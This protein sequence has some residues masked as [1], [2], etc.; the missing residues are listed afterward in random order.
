MRIERSKAVS[1]RI[2]AS[3][4]SG[5]LPA[6][7]RLPTHR[8]LARKHGIALATATKAY[9]EL[10]DAG[11]TVGERGRGTFVRDL[12]G[13]AGPDARRIP[14]TDRVADLSFNQPLAQEQPLALRR[15]LREL[16]SEG[17]L[18]SL[19]RQSPP[20]GH[21]RERAAVA[22]YLLGRGIDVPPA[23]V[24]LTN[25]A[26]HGLDTALATV[27]R[28]GAPLALD[29]LTYPGVKL[30]A[31]L[32]HLD[33]VP[34]RCGTDGTDLDALEALCRSRR[35]SAAYL[36]P[37]LHNPLG[38][39]LD[40]SARERVT[41]LARAYDFCLV[42]D[43][44]YAFLDAAAA[45]ALQAFAPERTFYVGSFSKNLAPGLRIG[46]L[47]VPTSH[48][49][50]VSRVLRATSWGVDTVAS[51]LVTRWLTDGTVHAMESAR[52]ADARVRQK[53]AVHE[54]AD[55]GYRAH[56]CAYHGWLALPDDAR[57]DLV[58]RTLAERGVLVSTGDAFATSPERANALRLALATPSM[59]QLTRGLSI[60]R[61]VV[62]FA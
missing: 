27:A 37:T 8:E 3:I 50:A 52:R 45:P 28:P 6:G 49:D 14:V 5:E 7:T 1:D 34:V 46:Y 47:V 13:F 29:S 32:R 53:A 36:M 18:A 21:M 24:V 22:T 55:L 19:L 11:L 43:A 62:G 20:G 26:Q 48:L 2:A 30:V 57:G 15:A 54:L 41:E 60:V 44:T 9:R 51:A 31:Q 12:S 58:A 16:A 35:V 38:F 10:A 42:E 33:L 17:D 23:N 4:R 39:V 25:G 40:T 59:E 56:P 61:E